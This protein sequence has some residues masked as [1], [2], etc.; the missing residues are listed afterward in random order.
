VCVPLGKKNNLTSENNKL[1]IY[2]IYIV[3]CTQSA[4]YRKGNP[5]IGLILF[6]IL[7]KTSIAKS[8]VH[9]SVNNI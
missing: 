7:T 9:A 3:L 8:S 4:F 1:V 6:F 2:Y 5:E